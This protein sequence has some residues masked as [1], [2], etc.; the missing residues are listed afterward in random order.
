MKNATISPMPEN[1]SAEYFMSQAIALAKK[2]LGYTQTNPLVGC[3]IVHNGKIIGQGYHTAYGQPHAEVEAVNSVADKALLPFSQMYVSLEPCCH[4]GKTPPCTNLILEHKIPEV[5][6]A[7]LDPFEKVKGQGIKVLAENGIKVT[8][9]TL[10]KEAKWMNRRFLVNQ[11]LG[12]PYII[13]KWAQSLDAKIAGPAGERIQISGQQANILNHSWRAQEM[14]IG[15]GYNTFVNDNPR[16]NN[17]SGAGLQPTPVVFGSFN[18]NPQDFFLTQGSQTPKTIFIG[19]ANDHPSSTPINAL[20]MNPYD[21]TNVFKALYSQGLAS[22]LIEGGAKLLHSLIQEGM[23]DEIRFFKSK[24]LK[25]GQGVDAPDLPAL[26]FASQDLAE[27][28]L[29]T[30]VKDHTFY[31]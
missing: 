8:V 10:E 23:Y 7:S 27:D 15:V 11:N 26:D 20:N 18:A 24:H 14:A 16:L 28:V 21:L 29:Y 2:G 31:S 13:L 25:L 5:F 9:G 6:V 1:N 30:F 17:R 12:R 4:Y 22:I 3:V 19:Q